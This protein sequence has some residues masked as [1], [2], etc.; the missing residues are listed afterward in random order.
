[1]SRVAS[2][3]GSPGSA[4]VLRDRLVLCL[5][6]SLIGSEEDPGHGWQDLGTSQI[7]VETCRQASLPATVFEVTGTV[8]TGQCV[9]QHSGWICE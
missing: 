1:M 8:S 2:T 4:T 9:P 7:L 5:G 3:H 6:G